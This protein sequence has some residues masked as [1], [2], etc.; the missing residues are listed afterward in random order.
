MIYRPRRRHCTNIQKMAC[1]DK[2][3]SIITS[4]TSATFE[5]QVIK[6][7]SNTEIDLKK[8]IAYNY[9][10]SAVEKQSF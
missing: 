10:F 2:I 8:S 4:S 9:L 5:V 3:M 7:L 1:V 6:K